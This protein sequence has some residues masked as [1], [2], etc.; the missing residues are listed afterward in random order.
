MLKFDF[1]RNRVATVLSA[2]TLMAILSQW[3][4]YD[5]QKVLLNQDQVIEEFCDSFLSNS[6]TTKRDGFQF[7]R[8]ICGNTFKRPNAT[9]TS[10]SNTCNGNTA[11]TC[12]GTD[13]YS[14]YESRNFSHI[15]KQFL[16]KITNFCFDFR[17]SHYDDNDD[18]DDFDDFDDY[19]DY[20]D[21]DDFDFDDYVDFDYDD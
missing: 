4:D 5:K 15:L 20:D 1:L 2:F 18:N 21:F 8:C 11:E 9:S 3:H 14:V 17:I 19:D 13:L 10:C 6:I 12:G 7:D 16:K